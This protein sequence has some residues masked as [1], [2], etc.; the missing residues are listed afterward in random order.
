MCL[1]QWTHR[2]NR[3]VAYGIVNVHAAG[4]ACQEGTTVLPA[5]YAF[6]QPRSIISCA[7]HSTVSPMPGFILL[8][9]A[10]GLEAR[11]ASGAPLLMRRP[12][13]AVVVISGCYSGAGC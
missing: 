3:C 1:P 5:V 6:A 7:R 12:R 11:C 13:V 2:Q 9:R 10:Y 8:R 4:A